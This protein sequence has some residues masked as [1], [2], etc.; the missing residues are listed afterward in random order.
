VKVSRGSGFAENHLPIVQV[1]HSVPGLVGR[2]AL[3]ISIHTKSSGQLRG[4]LKNATAL[5]FVDATG[6]LSD[7]T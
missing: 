1:A 2:L 5:E 6:N 3:N 7:E 4:T